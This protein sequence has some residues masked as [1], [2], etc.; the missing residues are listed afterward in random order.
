M[1]RHVAGRRQRHPL[2]Q[3]CPGAVGLA[4]DQVIISA[5]PGSAQHRNVFAHP[6]VEGV[7]DANQL[8]ALFAGSM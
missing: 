2:R 5:V 1:R 3:V 7:V 6:G 8:Y 4:N